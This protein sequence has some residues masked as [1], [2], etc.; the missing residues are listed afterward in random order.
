[1]KPT[2]FRVLRDYSLITANSIVYSFLG[3]DGGSVIE[4][5]E[6]MGTPFVAVTMNPKGHGVWMVIPQSNLIKA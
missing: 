1:M 6:R 2:K 3:D 5:E 4:A